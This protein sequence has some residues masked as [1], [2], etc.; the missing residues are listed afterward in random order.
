MSWR[1]RLDWTA[2]C[3]ASL[4][5]VGHAWRHGEGGVEEVVG[6]RLS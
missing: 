1:V 3:E 5:L 2:V 6:R 4:C